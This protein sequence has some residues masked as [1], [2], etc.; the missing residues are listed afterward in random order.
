[1][2]AQ[3]LA[4]GTTKDCDCPLDADHVATVTVEE[5]LQD[6]VLTDTVAEPDD[7]FT[8]S[9]EGEVEELIE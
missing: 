1:M 8:G 6:E 3:T 4:D 7:R 5:V 9:A 2:H